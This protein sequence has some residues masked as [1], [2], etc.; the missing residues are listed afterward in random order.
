MQRHCIRNWLLAYARV[1]GAIVVTNDLGMHTL[2]EDFGLKV[3]HGKLW[4]L[5]STHSKTPKQLAPKCVSEG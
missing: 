3:W 1:K 2:A 5:S 4:P